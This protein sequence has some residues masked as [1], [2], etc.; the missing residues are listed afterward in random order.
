M[1]RHKAGGQ[2]N[3]W[4]SAHYDGKEK[5][6]IQIGNS[7]LLD[8]RVH[9]L[10]NGAVKLYFC[11]AMESG[12]KTETRFTH[13]AAKKYGISSTSYDRYLKELQQAGFVKLSGRT[14]NSRFSPNILAFAFDWKS[15]SEK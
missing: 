1:P 13:S 8:K 6:F 7:F 9:A 4:L 3:P 15:T 14:G 11:I 12:G 2:L 10:S 5:R